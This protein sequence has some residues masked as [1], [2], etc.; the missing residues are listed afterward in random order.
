MKATS[1]WRAGRTES[2]QQH[3]QC[4][5]YQCHWYYDISVIDM[6]MISVSLIWL[7]YDMTTGQ[8]GLVWPI[9]KHTFVKSTYLT[10]K[11]RT[12]PG[13]ACFKVVYGISRTSNFSNFNFSFNGER[14]NLD[15]PFVCLLYRGVLTYSVGLPSTDISYI[16]PSQ[17]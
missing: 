8:P 5:W 10:T 16:W 3:Q 2:L 14:L 11:N 4:V 1:G 13:W 9:Y 15:K 17:I 12:K 6:I 7:W